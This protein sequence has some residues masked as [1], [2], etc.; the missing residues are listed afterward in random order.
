M[1]ERTT[2]AAWVK[3]IA[4]MLEA[5]GLDVPAL[6]RQAGFDM[7]ALSEPGARCDTEKLSLLWELAALQSGNPA[8]GVALPHVVKPAGF[9]LVAYVMMSCPTLHAALERMLRYLRIVSDAATLTL[10]EDKDGCWLAID[11]FG[12]S[13]PVP[14]QRYEFILATLLTFFRWLTARR[15]E[16][17]AIDLAHP[18]PADLRPYD[19]AFGCPLRFGQPQH[20]MRLSF[21][22]LTLPLPTSNP[23]LAE[24]HDRYAIERLDRMDHARISTKTR[25][26]IVSQLP[27]GEP[28]RGRVAK[29]LCMSERTL[30]RRLEDEGTSFHRLV[31]QTRREL[32]ER[33]LGQGRLSLAQTAYMLGFAD[34]SAFFRACKRWFDMSPGEYRGR[35]RN[36][37]P[38]SIK[39]GSGLRPHSSPVRIGAPLPG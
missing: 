12:G 2:S 25:E 11:L 1:N 6:F 27:D 23:V 36:T 7:A 19:E 30:Q 20:R 21:A 32:A 16:P 35:M 22:D 5:A 39:G 17:L 31:E 15:L 3:G 33:Y 34:Q 24:L 28:L 8:I 13:R 26:L 9:D 29:S 18:A 14:R 37:A 4:E 10:Q 38:G